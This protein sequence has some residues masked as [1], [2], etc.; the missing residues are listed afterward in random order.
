MWF[1]SK[2]SVESSTLVSSYY[3]KIANGQLINKRAEFSTTTLMAA[4]CSLCQSLPVWGQEHC[5]H[6]NMEAF[7]A[8]NFCGLLIMGW[9]RSDRLLRLFLIWAFWELLVLLSE[10]AQVQKS[11]KKK[12]MVIFKKIHVFHTTLCRPFSLCRQGSL[13]RAPGPP[14]LRHY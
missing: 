2:I 13:L 7:L 10:Q 9:L 14:S 4:A 5:L 6:R 3:E 11:E 8:S 12:Y 1:W